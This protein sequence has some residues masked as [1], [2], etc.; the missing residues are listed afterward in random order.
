MLSLSPHSNEQFQYLQLQ[1]MIITEKLLYVYNRKKLTQALWVIRLFSESLCSV[2][3]L[4]LELSIAVW[5]CDTCELRISEARI[6]KLRFAL[7]AHAVVDLHKHSLWTTCYCNIF[8]GPTIIV[9]YLLT[10]AVCKLIYGHLNF[11]LPF[12]GLYCS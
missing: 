12:S 4:R 11:V 3:E 9:N 2:H 7:S 10:N 8:I 1:L 5:S 6:H